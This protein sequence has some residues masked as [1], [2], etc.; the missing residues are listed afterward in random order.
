MLD[1]TKLDWLFDAAKIKDQKRYASRAV[2]MVLLDQPSEIDR[3]TRPYLERCKE[4]GISLPLAVMPVCADYEEYIEQYKIFL[5]ACMGLCATYGISSIVIP[6]LQADWMINQDFYD[7]IVI[8][9][10]DNKLQ[11]LLT[12]QVRNYNGHY[13]LSLNFE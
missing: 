9:A 6:P 3:L 10:Q 2:E 13:I 1:L 7:E 11:I 8:G 4:L 5:K 12:N